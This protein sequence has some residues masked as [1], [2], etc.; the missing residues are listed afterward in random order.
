MQHRRISTTTL[1]A[2]VAL[3]FSLAGTGV[4]ASHY[5]ITSVGQ[6]KPSVRHALKGAQGP[7]GP[8][9]PAGATGQ[10][11]P[12]GIQGASGPQGPAGVLG[13]VVVRS[14]VQSIPVGQSVTVTA[15]C[16]R[17]IVTG[18]GFI[19]R[20]MLV[21][22]SQPTVSYSDSGVADDYGWQIVVTNQGAN[23]LPAAATAICG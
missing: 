7:A 1:I 20:G 10:Q 9:G 11:G 23:P 21:Q 12:Q 13:S 5:L 6:I 18:G 16:G 19:A 15:D 3:F 2:S 4:A 22:S 14:G 17:R 8:A